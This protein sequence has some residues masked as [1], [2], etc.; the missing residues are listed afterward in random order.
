MSK[1]I[2][3]DA[4]GGIENIRVGRYEPGEP[5]AGEALVRQTVMGVNYSD[6]LMRKGSHGVTAPFILGREGLGVVEA[7]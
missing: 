6:V 4:I 7:R 3:V 5:K 1:A 2:W